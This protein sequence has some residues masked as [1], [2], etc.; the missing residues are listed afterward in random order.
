MAFNQ[1]YAE[2]YPYLNE[3]PYMTTPERAFHT[4]NLHGLGIIDYDDAITHETIY[5]LGTQIG[6][7]QEASRDSVRRAAYL[8]SIVSIKPNLEPDQDETQQVFSKSAMGMHVDHSARPADKQPTHF[9]LGCVEPPAPGNGG[10]TVVSFNGPIFDVLS[11]E[12]EELLSNSHQ[13]HYNQHGEVESVAEAT[14]IDEQR[15]RRFFSFWDSGEYGQA[16][17]VQ[18]P[19]DASEAEAHEAVAAIFDR[20][21]DPTYARIIPWKPNRVVVFNNHA[22]LHG[23]TAQ[24]DTSSREL[25]RGHIAER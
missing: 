22:L 14:F 18:T 6:K 9:L 17:D 21:L 8:G 25:L 7:V 5:D 11:K 12:Q 24:A 3:L 16:W 13:R 2:A 19:A 15:T 1:Q 20:M 4:A 10:D 23:R